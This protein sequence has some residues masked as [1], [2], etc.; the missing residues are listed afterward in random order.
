MALASRVGQ[1]LDGIP[2]SYL[3]VGRRGDPEVGANVAYQGRKLLLER[4]PRRL[5]I[6]HA[7]G[8][9]GPHLDDSASHLAA[10]CFLHRPFESPPRKRGA[11]DPDHDAI[12]PEA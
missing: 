1:F 6:R 4:L 10:G 2:H 7:R 5:R 9:E 3:D 8:T 12:V 11:V